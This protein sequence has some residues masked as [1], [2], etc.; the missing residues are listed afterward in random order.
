MIIEVNVKALGAIT[1]TMHSE[2]FHKREQ[3]MWR[4]VKKRR[5]SMEKT[6]FCSAENY[7]KNGQERKI[8]KE[9]ETARNVDNDRKW[10]K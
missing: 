2:N 9:K 6:P 5:R 10:E 3:K 4:M 8:I 7:D 1:E